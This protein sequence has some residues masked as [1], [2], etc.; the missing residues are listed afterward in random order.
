MIELDVGRIA[1]ADVRMLQGFAVDFVF[2]DLGQF[3]DEG[4]HSDPLRDQLTQRFL[5]C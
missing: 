5:H 3:V 2:G 4:F 1:G